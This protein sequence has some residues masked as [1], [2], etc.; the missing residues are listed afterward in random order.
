M[1]SI[2]KRHRKS[3][4]MSNNFRD[5]GQQTH[6]AKQQEQRDGSD[7]KFGSKPHLDFDIVER[8]RPD[9][10]S[11]QLAFSKTKCPSWKAGQGGNDDGES[12]KKNHIEID[13]FEEGRP[14][15][16]NYKLLISAI[17]PRFIGFVS[18]RSKDGAL[19]MSVMKSLQF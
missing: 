3:S 6:D 9:W 11:E 13:P 12:L 1:T 15:I 5:D 18:T 7:R 8:S 19:H 17:V 2:H 16:F 4:A 14:S 10:K